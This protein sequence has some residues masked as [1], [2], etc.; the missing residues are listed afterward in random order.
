MRY[1]GAIEIGT[2][3]T[4][5][6]VVIPDL[7]GCFSAGDTLDEAMIAAEEAV[8]AWLDA[9]FDAGEAIPPPTSLDVVRTRPEFAGWT[10][11][12]ITMDVACLGEVVEHVDIS[13]P[14]RVLSRLDAIARAHGR[15]RSEAVAHLTLGLPLDGFA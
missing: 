11:G 3:T 12:F 1:P 6:G 4:A 15:S 13:L 9:A 8:A 7:P 5:Y 2:D 14:R 10:F